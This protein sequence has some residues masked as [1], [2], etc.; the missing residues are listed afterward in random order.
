[1]R[2]QS[3][4]LSALLG[5]LAWGNGVA[6]NFARPLADG[7]TA[8]APS[9]CAVVSASASIGLLNTPDGMLFLHYSTLAWALEMH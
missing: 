9:P 7:P 2:S 4:Y 6:A 5:A 1:M 8:T 3:L